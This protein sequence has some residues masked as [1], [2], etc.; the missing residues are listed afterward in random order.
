MCD[1]KFVG[2]KGVIVELINVLKEYEIVF[3][4]V[5]GGVV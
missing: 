2:I 4:I 3:E 1:E 5:F